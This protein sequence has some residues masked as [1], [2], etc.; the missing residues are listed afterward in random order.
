MSTYTLHRY[1]EKLVVA[2]L[3][4]GA[5]V[6]E[7]AESASIFS[8]TATAAETSVVC[9]SRSVPRKVPQLGPYTAFAVAGPLDA[10]LVGVLLALL[11]PLAEAGITVMTI[12][13]HDTDW[14]LVPTG[15][16]DDAAEA[17]RRSGHTVEPAPVAP[18]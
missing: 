13:T 7:W 11:G 15:R 2:R 18:A 1:P 10:A 3:A 12:S 9:A 6:P 14:L 5:D 16:A 4:P 17:W 8:I